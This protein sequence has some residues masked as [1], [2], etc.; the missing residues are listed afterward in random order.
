[1]NLEQHAEREHTATDLRT[2]VID[3]SVLLSDP[4]AITRFAEHEVVVPI[5]VVSELE[6]KRHDPELGYFARM[7]LRLLDDLRTDHGGLASPVPI[8][9]DGG[10]LRV[11]LNHVSLEVLPSGMRGMDN[12]SRIL[13]V[14]KN[15]ANDGHSVTVVSK[16]VPM[17]VKASALGLS[18][19]EYRNE[20]VQ[21]SGWTGVEEVDVTES[22]MAA[23]Y[24]HEPVPIPEAAVLPINTSLVITSNRGS[25][26]GRVGSDQ[27]VRLVR[28][29]RDVFGLHG[30]SAEQRLAL[31]LLLDPEVGIVSLGGRAGT[32]KSALALCAGLE[33]VLERNEHRKVVVF[34]PLYA[35]GGQELGYL[36]GSESEKMNP[37]AQ[38]VFDTLGSVVSDT[39]MA[40][41]M[42]R[43]LLEVLPLTHIRGRSLHDSFVIVD[44]AQSLEKNV[45]LTVMSRIGQRSKIV[46]THDVAQRDNLRVGRHDGVVAVV[47]T[48][49]GNPLFGHV[50]LTRS[51]RSPI[52]ALVTELLERAE[53]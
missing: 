52:A 10:T 4:R 27:Q 2:Y 32:G 15:L 34:R 36:P 24:N 42:E 22:E 53:I 43:G 45:L 48:L 5:V 31:D 30:R 47:E 20:L 46:L 7:A 40:E 50:T 49:K 21:D 26:L 18:A 35:V 3:T 1:M 6:G 17:R 11:E 38:A 39:L 41:I 33:A 13:A 12:D 44:E 25:A 19:E 16:D 14:A 9:N 37:W 51:E 8:G 28:G 29:D 23:L